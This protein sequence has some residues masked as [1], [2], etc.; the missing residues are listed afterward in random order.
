MKIYDNTGY[1]F[2]AVIR[3]KQAFCG[4]CNNLIIAGNKAYIVFVITDYQW[5]HSYTDSNNTGE[6]KFMKMI[7]ITCYNKQCRDEYVEKN[8]NFNKQ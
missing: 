8:K 4:H 6:I 2:N 3:K 5:T 1:Q 7:G